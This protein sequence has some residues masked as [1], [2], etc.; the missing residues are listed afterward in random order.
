MINNVF[1]NKKIVITGDRGF[2]GS[3]LT[4]WLL[5][6]GADVYGF[7][8]QE[9]NQIHYKSLKLNY[10]SKDL[11]IRDKKSLEIYLKKINPDFIFHLAAQPIVNYSYDFP[12]DTWNTNVIGTANLLDISRS[13][14]N[15][16]GILV[17]TSDKCYENIEKSV[18]YNE[19]SRL[20]GYDPYSSSKAAA[21]ILTTSFYKSF[22]SN[23]GIQVATARAGNVIGGGDFSNDRLIPDII[24]SVKMN[25]K[26][27]IRNPES[28]RPWQHV[29]DCLHGYLI[30]ADKLINGDS[31]YSRPWNFGPEEK[32]SYN[33]IS[34]FNAFSKIFPNLDYD[35]VKIKKHEAKIL[36]LDSSLA[37]KKLGWKTYLNF[38]ETVKL[39]AEWYKEFF[40]NKNVI[41]LDQIYQ[42]EKK[43]NTF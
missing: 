40:N 33:V 3:W 31:D 26:L 24:Q 6:F 14:N 22:F 9:P 37:R 20:G 8:I 43:I 11:D 27:K 23:L 5:K 15:L 2:K 17:I 36:Q 38:S 41:S 13:L 7:S 25:K 28:I 18:F 19:K 35:E 34:I 12:L 42:F 29:L 21:D 4:L 10:E 30:L 1:K 39:T 16:K 32:A